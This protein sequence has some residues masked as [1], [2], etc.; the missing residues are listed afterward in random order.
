M[1]QNTTKHFLL[2]SIPGFG[3]TIPMVGLARK[4]TARNHKVTFVIC[5]AAVEHIRKKSEITPEDEKSIDLIG[6]EDGIP[7]FESDDTLTMT[8]IMK[9]KDHGLPALQKLVQGIPVAGQPPADAKD[10]YGITVP[11]NALVADIFVAGAIV[12]CV[13]RKLPY[14]FLN[15]SAIGPFRTMLNITERTPVKESEEV[16][17]ESFDVVPPESEGPQPAIS[18]IMKGLCLSINQFLATANGMLVNS[19][20]EIEQKFIDEVKRDPRMKNLDFYCVG[21]FVPEEKADTNP[22]HAELGQKVTRWLDRQADK[23]VVYV[24]FGSVVVP[25]ENRI[26]EV[27]KALQALKKPFIFSIRQNQQSILPGDVRVGIDTHLDDPEAPGLFLHWAPQKLILAHR[28]TAVF[29]SHC[30]WN[31][32]IESLFSGKPVVGWPIFGDQLENALWIEQLGLGESLIRPEHAANDEEKKNITSDKIAATVLRVGYDNDATHKAALKWKEKIRAA[33][34]P[35]G[36]SNRELQ[37][38]VD[39]IAQ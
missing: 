12:G 34:G 26:I 29:V 21:P 18:H 17:M 39:A 37:D 36:S 28:A 27:A 32:T 9:F 1:A 5:K 31:S 35:G 4:L 3:H 6:L 11:V 23:S 24:S 25:N 15:C 20:R 16:D 14:Y 19:F 33:V 8:S 2:I 7:D 10:Q 30:G 13:E 22:S 38:F